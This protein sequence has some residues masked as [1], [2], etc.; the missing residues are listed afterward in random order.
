MPADVTASVIV[1]LVVQPDAATTVAVSTCA[2]PAVQAVEV[3]ATPV[4]KVRV[5]VDDTPRSNASMA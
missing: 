1:P 3:V 4:V 2:A 5:R